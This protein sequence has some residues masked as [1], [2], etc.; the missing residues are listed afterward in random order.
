MVVRSKFRIPGLKIA[1]PLTSLRTGSG[2]PEVCG[3]V[4]ERLGRVRGFQ[5]IAR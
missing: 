4:E 3:D 1:D 2:A 5:P